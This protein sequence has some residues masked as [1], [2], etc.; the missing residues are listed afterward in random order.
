M[1]P[2]TLP[3]LEF[4]PLLFLFDIPIYSNSSEHDG[5]RILDMTG[6]L[7]GA[8]RQNLVFANRAKSFCEVARPSDS[9][10]LRSSAIWAFLDVGECVEAALNCSWQC[11]FSE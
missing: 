5:D 11:L 3:S 2:T 7:G 1:L 9:R 10:R 8:S 4:L 6:W